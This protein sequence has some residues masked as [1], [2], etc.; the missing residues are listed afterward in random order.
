MRAV[1]IPDEHPMLVSEFAKVIGITDRKIRDW[2]QKEDFPVMA[3]KTRAAIRINGPEGFEWM[4]QR[5]LK[6]RGFLKTSDDSNVVEIDPAG[7]N[8]EKLRKVRAERIRLETANKVREGELLEAANVRM[9]LEG[10]FVLLKN[11][12]DGLAGRMSAGNAVKRKSYLKVFRE[13]LIQFQGQIRSCYADPDNV[14]T[15]TPTTG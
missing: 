15:S 11:L 13:I 3:A 5:E 12:L 7:I 10:A 2:I 1:K 14:E 4:V 6:I 9:A 8:A